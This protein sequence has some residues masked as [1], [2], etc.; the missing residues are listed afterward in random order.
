MPRSSRIDG[1]VKRLGKASLVILGKS[2]LADPAETKRWIEHFASQGLPCL[3]LNAREPASVKSVR[4]RVRKI[5]TEAGTRASPGM[6]RTMRRLMV[7]GIP[8]VGKSTLINALA[9]RRAARVANLP[10]VTRHIQWVKL[11]GD[12]EL[13]DLPGVLDFALVRRGEVLR[14][15]NTVPGPNDDP[16][17]AARFLVEMLVSTGHSGILP[18]WKACEESWVNFLGRYALDR[19]FLGRGG[20]F[21]ERRA[22]ID[23]VKRFQDAVFGRV[24]FEKYDD[25]PV[26]LVSTEHQEEADFDPEIEV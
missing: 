5:A 2:D 7:I 16:V 25:P 3:A 10:G 17:G 18:S 11:P 9:G 24:T 19:H 21:D 14:M 1:L 13:L 22:A 6:K 26:T 20:E 12:L 15:I 4:E 23:F 8:N